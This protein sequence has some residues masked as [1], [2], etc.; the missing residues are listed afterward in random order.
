M[1]RQ[2]RS[3]RSVLLPEAHGFPVIPMIDVMLNLLIFFMLISHYMQPT[4]E[5]SLPE[6]SSGVPIEHPDIA[7]AV[8]ADGNLE[9]DGQGAEWDALPQRLQGTDPQ[10]YVRISADEQTPYDYIVQVMDAAAQANLSHIAL[11]TRPA[12]AGDD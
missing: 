2:R 4:L 3:R 6:A 8:D 11:E 9:V 5:V 12:I 1:R 10:T 7:I